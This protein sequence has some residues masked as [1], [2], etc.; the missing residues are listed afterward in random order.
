MF[1]LVL[2]VILH[3]SKLKIVLYDVMFSKLLMKSSYSHSKLQYEI[4]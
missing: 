2:V 3:C 1:A 4:V